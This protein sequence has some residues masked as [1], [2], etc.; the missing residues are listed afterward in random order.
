MQV[1]FKFSPGQRVTTPFGDL[2]IV[3][4]AGVD[5]AGTLSYF[6]KTATGGNWFNEDQLTA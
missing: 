3:S 6:V 1:T 4:T 2:G 5:E